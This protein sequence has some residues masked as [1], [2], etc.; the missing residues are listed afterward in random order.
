MSR[1]VHFPDIN[2]EQEIAKGERRLKHK[3]TKNRRKPKM[4]STSDQRNTQDDENTK[5]EYADA[6]LCF[7]RFLLA[8]EQNEASSTDQIFALREWTW[9]RWLLNDLCNTPILATNEAETN[10]IELL[11]YI[12]GSQRNWIYNKST[13]HLGLSW[14]EK[15][16]SL[17]LYEINKDQDANAD[18]DSD[19]DARAQSQN[20]DVE[21]LGLAEVAL[22]PQQGENLS[23]L[24]FAAR[25]GG[26]QATPSTSSITQESDKTSLKNEN[27]TV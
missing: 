3:H 25:S 7:I 6:V 2:W 12:L 20:A 14:M 15:A 8:Q 4:Q 1:H 16:R 11:E 9:F 23:D 21:M 10:K 19:V 5:P 18:E 17:Q 22:M 27:R 26:T 24:S 13:V